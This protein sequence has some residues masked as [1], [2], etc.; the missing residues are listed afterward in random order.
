MTLRNGKELVFIQIQD[1]KICRSP[2]KKPVVV[3]VKEK[4]K[5][6]DKGKNLFPEYHPKMPYL[7]KV[8]N[9]QQDEQFKKFLEMFK[10]LPINVPFVEALD[11][12]MRYAMFLKNFLT[13][14]KKLEEMSR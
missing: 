8:R 3:E 4:T 7:A 6:G 14:K 5:G 13:N 11:Q 1:N 12:I 10:T 2:G 9:D